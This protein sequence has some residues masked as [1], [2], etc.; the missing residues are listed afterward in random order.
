MHS[1]Q[2]HKKQMNTFYNLL[3]ED[4]KNFIKIYQNI[5]NQFN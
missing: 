2:M 3:L 5:F 1:I 4:L